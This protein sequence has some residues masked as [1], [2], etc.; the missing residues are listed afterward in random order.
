MSEYEAIKSVMG[1]RGI[2]EELPRRCRRKAQLRT[3][4]RPGPTSSKL[5]E[6]RRLKREVADLCRANEVFK[7]AFLAAKLDRPATK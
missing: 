5:A 7:P 4:K 1:K 2:S 6:I 3:G